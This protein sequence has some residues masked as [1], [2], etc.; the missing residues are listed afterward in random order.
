MSEEAIAAGIRRIEAVAGEEVLRWAEN[1]A[2]R[3]DEKFAMLSKKKAGPAALPAFVKEANASAVQSVETR[4]AHLKRL[5]TEVH[6][7]EKQNA[8]TAEVRV[9]NRALILANECWP[10]HTR[11]RPHL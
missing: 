4:A 5:E 10:R 11:A 2:A 7:W 3:Q 9:A 6:D 8:K 1:Q